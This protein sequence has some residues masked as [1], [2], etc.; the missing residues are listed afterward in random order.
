MYTKWSLYPFYFKIDISNIFILKNW[1][2]VPVEQPLF[3]PL[4]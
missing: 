3:F 2:F 1:N 4:P